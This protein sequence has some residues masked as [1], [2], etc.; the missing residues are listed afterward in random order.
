MKLGNFEIKEKDLT[1][2][3]FDGCKGAYKLFYGQAAT[4]GPY[5]LGT[6]QQ[7]KVKDWSKW[8]E[9]LIFRP[10]FHHVAGIYAKISPVL[11]EATKYIN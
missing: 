5:T 3:R 9:R 6:Y 8:E 1:V 2:L 7:I 11:F 10:Y 4:N